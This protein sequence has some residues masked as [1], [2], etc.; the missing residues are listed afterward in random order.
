MTYFI[1]LFQKLFTMVLNN[2]DLDK[3]QTELKE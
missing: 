1:P 3:I 2:Q